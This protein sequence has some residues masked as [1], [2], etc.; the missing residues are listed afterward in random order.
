MFQTQTVAVKKGDVF[1]LLLSFPD[2][3]LNIYHNGTRVA[4]VALSGRS[5]LPLYPFVNLGTFSARVR[6]QSLS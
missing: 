5:R 3:N 4:R 1:G 2:D 6:N